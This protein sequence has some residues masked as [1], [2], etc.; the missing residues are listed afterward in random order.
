MAEERKT[1]DELIREISVLRRQL[2]QLR[3]VRV[4]S[5]KIYNKDVVRATRCGDTSVPTAKKA[6]RACG[7]VSRDRG[8]AKTVAEMRRRLWELTPREYEV[9][10]HVIAGRL[11]KQTA[12][13]MGIC[14]KTVKVHRG[15]VMRKMQAE[16]LAELVRDAEKAG[17]PALL[18]YRPG[19]RQVP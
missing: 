10:R 11:N 13:D 6:S 1:K 18:Q 5:G 12:A 16:S 3:A 4:Q 8:G 19:S 9:F 7:S 15:R 17:V 14:E 2:R